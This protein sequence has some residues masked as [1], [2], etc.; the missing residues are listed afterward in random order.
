MD[1]FAELSGELRPAYSMKAII[2][3]P[4]KH[5]NRFLLRIAS[6]LKLAGTSI[7]LS[8]LRLG[9]LVTGQSGD[10]TP[11]K[12][13]ILKIEEDSHAQDL[14]LG[15]PVPV[16]PAVPSQELIPARSADVQSNQAGRSNTSSSHRVPQGS[17]MSESSLPS[18][19]VHVA[20]EL[21]KS[22]LTKHRSLVFQG[23]AANA[24]A[25]RRRRRARSPASSLSTV[26]SSGQDP[27]E[28]VSEMRVTR[29]AS[30][31]RSLNSLEPLH[32]LHDH[33]AFVP[34]LEFSPNRKYLAT[35]R[36]VLR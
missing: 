6:S 34:H 3:E 33:T 36:F 19:Q 1:V 11:D 7:S 24:Q 32:D 22:I 14:E 17:N 10:G 5:M 27:S 15:L 25:S 28:L 16:L 2:L 35:C 20:A 12:E 31:I 4:P 30:L 8:A 9:L 21:L 23:A 13:D 29:L 26:Q 18:T